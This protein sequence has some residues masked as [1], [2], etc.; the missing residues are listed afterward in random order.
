MTTLSAAGTAPAAPLEAT[1]DEAHLASRVSALGLADKVRLLTG[2]TAWRLHPLE[3]VG[4]RSMALS[5]GPAGVRGI[6][7]I[8]GETS[9]SFPAPSA[10]AATWDVTL[11]GRLGELFA[12]EARAHGVDVVLAPVVNLQRTPAG[13]RHF[14][15]YS[16][17]PLL[18][19]HVAGAL[20]E[21]LQAA[22]V[23]A[24]VKHLVG[25]ESET[26]RTTYLARMDER[27]LREVYLAPFEHTLLRSGA[28]TVMAAYNGLDDGTEAATATEHHGLL[29]RILKEEWGYDG[30]VVSDW[31]A[32]KSDVRS[33]AAG[34]DLVMPGPG[35]PWAAGLLDAVRAGAV[36][37]AVID[38]KVLRLL[39]LAD[40]VGALQQPA[41]PTG[42][43][44]EPAPGSDAGP[45]PTGGGAA[46]L[47][48]LAARSTVVLRNAD[49][50]LPLDLPRAD[51]AAVRIALLGPNAVD[52]F[53]QGGGSAHVTPQHVVSPEEGLRTALPQAE[54][55]V[56][57]GGD[58]RRHAPDLDI[59]A[60]VT[61]P[62]AEEPGLLV[63]VL[64]A[65][66][67]VLRSH[68]HTGAW[69]GWLRGE[70]DAAAVRLRGEIR[71]DAPGE[72]W[73]GIG[74]VGACRLVLDGQVLAEESRRVGAEVILDSS[75][76]SPDDRGLTISVDQA[77]T[78]LLEAVVQNVVTDG[79]GSFA[80]AALRHRPPGPSIDDEIVEA[81]RL[82]AR[83]DVVVL[84]VGTNDEVESEGY[85]RPSLAL[86]GRQDELV[87]RVLDVA[88]DA[89]VV[90]NAGAPCVL[91]WL[92]RARTVLWTWFPGQ[93]CGAALADVLL[94]RTEP[95]GRLPWTLPAAEADV[96]VPSAVPGP[97]DRLDYIEGLHVGYRS[98]ERLERTPA[99]PFGHGLGWTTWEYERV[100]CTDAPD[101]GLTLTVGLRNTGPRT[102]SEVVQ[103]YLEPPAGGPERPVRWLAGFSVAQLPAG[104]RTEVPVHIPLRALQ[105]WDPARRRWTVPPGEYR[106]RVGRSIRDL[107]LDG[108]A[109]RR[110]E[111]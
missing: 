99:A 52:A 91:P 37:E 3:Q 94:G 51:G 86:P 101:G 60:L 32:T 13:G 55:T 108:T 12:S 17:D 4:L 72:H 5:D 28:W 106:F 8:A 96:P 7:E 65:T 69:S 40:R 85:D 107:R 79:Y 92:E 14:E 6:G 54:V 46:L 49:G 93:E 64:D 70:T 102:G 24:C 87:D 16:E 27:T 53:V 81:V 47:R 25:N 43:A 11:A 39:R 74:T 111:I 21:H 22:G 109:L 33:A 76:N 88:P 50:A 78:V 58:A 34:L 19:A 103:A 57:R 10:L 41:G 44:V 42:A 29:R 56:L 75:V 1:S 30:V 82:A 80:R 2:A 31:L 89:V 98:W 15:C 20:V 18:T 68:R 59:D 23:G 38:D 97:D 26:G 105:V 77:R 62:G 73:L 35:G 100:D 9:L 63:E 61:V 110:R 84:V 83:A 48:E 95:A 36:P 45:V 90:V 66:G 67:A 104:E 71:L